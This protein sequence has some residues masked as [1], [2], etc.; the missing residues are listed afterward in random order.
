MKLPRFRR[1]AGDAPAGPAVL[2][3]KVTVEWSGPGTPPGSYTSAGST[4]LA[5]SV[6]RSLM[7]ALILSDAA[8]SA[9][10][11]GRVTEATR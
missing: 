11:D 10:A 9:A 4:V 5:P 8:R 1:R 2:D 3:W 6:T 7:T